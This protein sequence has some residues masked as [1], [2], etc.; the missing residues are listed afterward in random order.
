MCIPCC[1]IQ[2]V[3]GGWLWCWCSTS[4]Y[5]GVLFSRLA[6][7]RKCTNT[8]NHR[9]KPNTPWSFMW[10]NG[11]VAFGIVGRKNVLTSCLFDVDMCFSSVAGCGWM[12]TCARLYYCYLHMCVP[13]G[14]YHRVASKWWC[15]FHVV[16]FKLWVV[17]GCGVWCSTSMYYGVL[18]LVW[19]K[20]E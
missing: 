3:G 19:Q 8:N 20:H 15:V 14:L 11:A 5:Y 1:L 17:V 12:L 10:S 6:E 4:T 18:F 16:W 2:V 7:A 9:N 13:T